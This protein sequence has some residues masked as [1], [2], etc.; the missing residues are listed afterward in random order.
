MY[1]LF[2]VTSLPATSL[3]PRAES[4]P[5]L[6][7]TTNPFPQRLSQ[8]RCGA[9]AQQ[10]SL[11]SRVTPAKLGV[12]EEV[13]CQPRTPADR[14]NTYVQRAHLS[15]KTAMA[16]GKLVAGKILKIQY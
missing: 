1:F 4:A 7:F 9:S 12:A 5:H 11:A 16:H 10:E 15:Y 2:H 6:S 13:R 14:R 8:Q 3:R